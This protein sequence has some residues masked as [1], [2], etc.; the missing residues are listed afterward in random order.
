MATPNQR[1]NKEANPGGTP[2]SP[3]SGWVNYKPVSVAAMLRADI[4]YNAVYLTQYT[5]IRFPGD[6]LTFPL[7]SAL[8]LVFG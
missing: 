7:G 5:I 2:V 3:V 6:S 4:N 8:G 1:Y